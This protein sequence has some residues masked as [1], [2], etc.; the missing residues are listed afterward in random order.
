MEADLLSLQFLFDER[1]AVEPV[2]GR[3]GKETR[4]AHDDGSQDCIPDIEVVVGEAASLVRQNAMVRIFCREFGHADAEGSALL[5]ALEDEV[6]AVGVLLLYAAQRGQN[7]VLFAG[8]FLGPLDRDL[9][10]AG[11]RLDPVP[12]VV[13]AL[14]EDL[15]AHHRDAK[16]L[17]KKIDHLL[18]PGQT[19]QVPMNDDAV[20]AVINQGQQIR[21]Q[22]DEPFHV[23][24][25]Y[26]M[27]RK[28][29]GPQNHQTWVG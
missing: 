24:A 18:G 21:E 10:V 29:C 22:L 5:H 1:V 19:A 4:H 26:S 25:L 13:G 14:A 3:K 23:H 28:N 15:F 7:V 9:V 12:V 6:D 27:E 8:P 20:E 16:D 17:P 2:G 11:V